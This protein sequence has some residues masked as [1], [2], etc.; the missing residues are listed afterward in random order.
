MKSKIE[1]EIMQLLSFELDGSDE[2]YAEAGAMSW[3][4]DNVKMESYM[5]GGLGAGIGRVFTGES[6]FMVRFKSESGKGMVSFTPSF[7]GKILPLK[8]GPGKEIICQKDA[9]LAAE[10][11]VNL[12]TI[13]RKKLGIGLF[14]G[15]GFLLQKLTGTGNAFVEIDGEVFEMDL[16][17]GEKLKVDTG[18]IAMFETTVKYDI[19]MVKG[20][21]NIIF[22]GEGLFLAT[23]EGPGKVWLQTMP[24]SSLVRKLLPYLPRGG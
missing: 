21:K 20:V 4:S 18:S 16:K 19:E 2:I 10:M 17:A 6:L 1:G 9:F 22:G 8:I 24:A 5:R 13:F 7:P 3:M 14:G 12:E 11:S 23:L 15:E